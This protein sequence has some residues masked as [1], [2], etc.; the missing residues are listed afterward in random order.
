MKHI[1]LWMYWLEHFGQ[2]TSKI[3][4]VADISSISFCSSNP[5][6]NTHFYYN[7]KYIHTNLLGP[8]TSAS[9]H[10][11][12][13][14]QTAF[15][16]KPKH[17][18]MIVSCLHRSSFV[19]HSSVFKTKIISCLEFNK[20]FPHIK[21]LARTSQKLENLSAEKWCQWIFALQMI[22]SLIN[23]FPVRCTVWKTKHMPVS[24]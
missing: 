17:T 10:A 7:N 18:E 19:H 12:L 6:K 20:V 21:V 24:S 22:L 4:V 5:Y 8:R 13:F 11:S 3:V 14:W 23:E 9:K 2:M 15:W 1:Q 16:F